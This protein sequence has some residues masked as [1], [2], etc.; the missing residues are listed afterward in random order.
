MFMIFLSYMICRS[1]WH[2]TAV[3]AAI[4]TAV[5]FRHHSISTAL[6]QI[7][8]CKCFME[9]HCSVVSGTAHNI[10]TKSPNQAIICRVVRDIRYAL[11]GG[12][13]TAVSCP[14]A[15][16]KHSHQ[17]FVC[18]SSRRR[19]YLLPKPVLTSQIYANQ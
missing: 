16:A 7:S 17:S 10:R 4:L 15:F 14:R 11:Y 19:P 3:I 5:A 6:I 18:F 9:L 12:W 1:R 2:Y 8:Q 13:R